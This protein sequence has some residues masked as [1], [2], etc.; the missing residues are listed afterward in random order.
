[1]IAA[2]S[3]ADA[4]IATAASSVNWQWYSATPAIVVVL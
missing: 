4:P 3:F 2:W 1:M